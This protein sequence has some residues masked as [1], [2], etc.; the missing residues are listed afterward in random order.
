MTTTTEKPTAE[1]RERIIP[2]FYIFEK[3][4][5]GNSK[6]IGAAFKHVK[7]KGLSILIDKQRYSAFP[8]KP[9]A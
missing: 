7:G 9:K 8:P 2:D 6:R 5:E 3:D 4:N 1:K